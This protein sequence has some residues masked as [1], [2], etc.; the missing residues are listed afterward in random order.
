MRS[1]VQA[2]VG[3]RTGLAAIVALYL[4]LATLYAWFTPAWQNPDE[5]AHYNYIRQLAENGSLPVLQAG[6]YDQQYLADIVARRFPPQLSI[7]ALRYEGHQPP[8]YY[9]LLAPVYRAS[10]GSLLALRLASAL[11]GALLVVCAGLAAWEYFQPQLP[12]AL[13]AAAFV[14]FIPQHVAMLASVNNDALAE[15]WMMLGL[16][17]LLRSSAARHTRHYWL[18]SLV[19]GLCFITKA[20]VYILLLPMLLA[21]WLDWRAGRSTRGAAMAQLLPALLL[22]GLWWARNAAVYGWPDVL[23]LQRH[24]AVVAG[25]PRTADWL[26]QFGAA[27]LLR[28]MLATT[29][30]SFWGQFGWMSAPMSGR[31]YA[32][33]WLLCAAIVAGLWLGRAAPT[34]ADTTAVRRRQ[35]LLL[36][37]AAGGTLLAFLYYNFSFVQHQ[38]RY[39]F[40]ALLPLAIAA[41]R[42]LSVWAQRCAARWP[43]ASRAAAWLPLSVALLLAA[44]CVWVLPL[45]AGSAG[46]A[47]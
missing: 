3:L 27:Q 33:L 6:D 43:A 20:T 11:L 38:G 12:L 47:L 46:A 39:L 35:H 15:L 4:L 8:L 31:I 14:A 16:W 28:R 21:L 18:A 9:L 19:L 45:I 42:G 29:F 1:A 36:L 44:L 13:A 5:P 23:G 40:P 10:N 41:T 26:A 24:A 25:Q 30:N 7:A 22:G 17:L 2:P 32:L 37:A 34:S